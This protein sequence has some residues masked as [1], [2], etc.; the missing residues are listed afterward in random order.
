MRLCVPRKR[1][2]WT[3]CCAR[4]YHAAVDKLHTCERELRNA[5]GMYCGSKDRHLESCHMFA[6]SHSQI[7][8]KR[9]WLSVVKYISCLY[10][11][12]LR[13]PQKDF[14]NENFQ[15]SLVHLVYKSQKLVTFLGSTM[16]HLFKVM[17]KII[18]DKCSTV[19]LHHSIAATLIWNDKW[20][21]NS[22]LLHNP[23]TTVWS[24]H[25]YGVVQLLQQICLNDEL[26]YL[27]VLTN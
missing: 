6:T 19:T 18:C 21:P 15:I 13:K 12:G 20:P 16:Y 17:V 27:A 22:W 24:Y 10:F 9:A 3:S 5:V 25:F 1:E 7:S 11:H 2:V 26:T 23:V 4:G 14:S 8:K